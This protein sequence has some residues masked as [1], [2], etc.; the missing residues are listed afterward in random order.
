MMFCLVVEFS[1]LHTV[2]D[3]IDRLAYFEDVGST[4]TVFRDRFESKG[5]RSRISEFR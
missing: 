1:G 5:L 3:H 2:G 4:I